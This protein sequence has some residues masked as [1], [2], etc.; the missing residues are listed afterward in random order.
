M[1]AA[2]H[3]PAYCLQVLSEA[4]KEAQL[5]APSAAASS[6]AVGGGGSSS[7]QAVSP[8]STGA[9]QLMDTNLTAFEVRAFVSQSER[10]MLLAPA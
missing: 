9:A 6:Q 10:P 2:Q 3:R 4:I 1:L 5:S 7:S 8:L